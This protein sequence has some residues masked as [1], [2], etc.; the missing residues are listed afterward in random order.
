MQTEQTVSEWEAS[1]S[2]FRA[3]TPDFDIGVEPHDHFTWRWWV[4]EAEFGDMVA[5]G[6][7]SDL[8]T[9]QKAAMQVGLLM[10]QDS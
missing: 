8:A 6:Y 2:K 9:A 3:M 5:T 7:A 10:E 1:G 4:K